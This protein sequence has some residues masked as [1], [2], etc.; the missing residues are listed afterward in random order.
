[1]NNVV[2]ALRAEALMH[3]TMAQALLLNADLSTLLTA[4]QAF[5]T[6]S[7]QAIA[8]LIA[9]SDQPDLANEAAQEHQKRWT[10]AI[11]EAV[12]NPSV[13]K[14]VAMQSQLGQ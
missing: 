12:A 14:H 11:A 5:M 4:S 13:R 9:S 3:K 7:E 2:T 10:L 1:M 6:A 8:A